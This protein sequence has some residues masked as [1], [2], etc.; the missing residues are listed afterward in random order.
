[1]RFGPHVPKSHT[2]ALKCL[3]IVELTAVGKA[4][5]SVPPHMVGRGMAG[6]GSRLHWSDA[7]EIAAAY[8]ACGYLELFA[9]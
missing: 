7:A 5:V 4:R 8:I 2:A 9:A 3:S 6:P 1:M